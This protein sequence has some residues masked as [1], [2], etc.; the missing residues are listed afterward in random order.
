MRSANSLSCS[1]YFF[2]QGAR[3]RAG[4]TR[5]IDR[6]EIENHFLVTFIFPPPSIAFMPAP[7][8]SRIPVSAR[9]APVTFTFATAR[10]TPS[11]CA[12]SS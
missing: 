10:E 11:T 9:R 7:Y 3:G 8:A 4:L 5:E 12:I 2:D 6:Q 1:M